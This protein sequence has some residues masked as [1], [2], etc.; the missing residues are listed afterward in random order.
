MSHEKKGADLAQTMV[1]I[2]VWKVE[3]WNGIM[4]YLA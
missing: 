2:G 3:D 1:R 4:R